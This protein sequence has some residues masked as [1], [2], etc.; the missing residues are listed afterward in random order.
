MLISA[1]NLEKALDSFNPELRS[2]GNRVYWIQNTASWFPVAFPITNVCKDD[3][4]QVQFKY[5]EVP[6]NGLRNIMSY[7]RTWRLFD[8]PPTEAELNLPWND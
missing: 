8:F 1:E 2:A 5:S 4:D 3:P 7:N 6:Y